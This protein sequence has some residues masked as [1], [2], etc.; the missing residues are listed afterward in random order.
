[1]DL[2]NIDVILNKHYSGLTHTEM[3]NLPFYE[4]SLKLKI[5]EKNEKEES[6]RNS[7]GSTSTNNQVSKYQSMANNMMS[8]K[9]NI[10]SMNFP[11]LK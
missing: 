11:T 7:E 1:M 3:L 8:S 5:I 4:Y 9:P 10:P 2:F 6:E